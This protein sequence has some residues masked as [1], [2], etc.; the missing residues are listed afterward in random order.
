M[1]RFLEAQK[2]G[3]IFFHFLVFV[4]YC[5]KRDKR[6]LNLIE[7]KFRLNLDDV[8]M[9]YETRYRPCSFAQILHGERRS[10]GTG[11][12]TLNMLRIFNVEKA[13]L[14]PQLT[15]KRF[16][17]LRNPRWASVEKKHI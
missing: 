7:K 10:R 3:E 8:Q 6:Q 15:E 5:K 16:T 2:F 9:A 1:K 11:S 4:L 13:R 12:F 14:M 17:S